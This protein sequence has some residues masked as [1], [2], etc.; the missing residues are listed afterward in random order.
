M[1]SIT[2]YKELKLEENKHNL[3]SLFEEA[4]NYSIVNIHEFED[5]T[6]S[7]TIKFITIKHIDLKASSGYNHK[8]IEDALL[9]A[10]EKAK[11]IQSQFK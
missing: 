7:A 1:F 5:R 6:I 9:E 8:T 2:K 3:K 10:I 4:R 11:L